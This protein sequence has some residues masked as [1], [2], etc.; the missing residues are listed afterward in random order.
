MGTHPANLAVRFLLEV[1]AY[2]VLGMLGWHQRI[3]GFRILIALAIPAC[4]AVLWATF[5]VPGDPSR[6]GSAPVPVSGMVRL[7]LECGFFAAAAWA[8]YDLRFTTL[9]AVFVSAVV[10]HYALSYDRIQWLLRQ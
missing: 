1:S 8:L 5:A 10:V 6:S 4:G 7:V 9:T 2:S 3:D